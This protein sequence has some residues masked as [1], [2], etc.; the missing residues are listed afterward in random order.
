MLQLEC[1]SAYL[2]SFVH[3]KTG[4]T[5]SYIIPRVNIEWFN[6]ALKSSHSY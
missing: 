2:Y 3:P 4:Q 5:E 6:L 1:N